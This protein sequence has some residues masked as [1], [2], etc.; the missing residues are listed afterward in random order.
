MLDA[1]EIDGIQPS[2]GG[3]GSSDHGRL[4]GH[5]LID[6]AG[7]RPEHLAEALER[8][9]LLAAKH[10]YYL[11]GRILIG[12]GYVNVNQVNNALAVQ[13]AASRQAGASK[14][15][16]ASR[17]ATSVKSEVWQ[18]NTDTG[19]VRPVS[20]L[21]SLAAMDEKVAAGELETMLPVPLGFDPLDEAL[22]GGLRPRELLLLG[23]SQ[24]VGKTTMAF[25][26]ARNIAASE[27]ANCLYVCYEHDEENLTQRLLAMESVDPYSQDFQLGVTVRDLAHQIMAGRRRGNEGLYDLLQTDPRSATALERLR[28]YGHRMFLLK[29]SSA[30]TTLAAINALV[31]AHRVRSDERLVLF[32]DYLQKVPVVPEPPTEQERITKVVEGLKE[33]AMSFEIPVV[34]VVASDR[35]GLKAKRMRA[36]HFAGGSALAYEADVILMLSD[37]YDTV[38]R[39][40]IEFNPHKAQSYR[41]WV[42]C[43]IEKNRSGRDIVDME[44]EKRFSYCCLNPNGNFVTE[45]LIDERVYVE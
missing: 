15:A 40:H 24:G 38:A 4:I 23:G 1:N 9:K 32:V 11:L 5:I 28:H 16:A 31:E 26:M 7:L 41:D 8:Q 18:V 6:T 42:V 14:G 22:G 37:K 44:F 19:P 43:S 36:H 45:K 35:E 34:A 33:L 2:D 20:A 13:R 39:V 27:E 29:G 17:R 25:Q 12:L 30:R 21:Q 10:R 3:N